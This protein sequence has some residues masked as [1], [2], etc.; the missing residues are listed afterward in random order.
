MVPFID[1]MLVLLVI[2]MVTAPMLTPGAIDVPSAHGAARPAAEHIAH[3]MLDARGAR[4]KLPDAH[5]ERVLPL[6]DLARAAAQWQRTQPTGAAVL[7]QADKTL[8]YERVVEA[9]SALRSA[10]VERVALG[11]HQAQP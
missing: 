5:P 11:V 1:V 7:I 3:V 2:F 8:P 6:P 9:M 4:L 10:G